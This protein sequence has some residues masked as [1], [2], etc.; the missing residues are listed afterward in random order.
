MGE[1]VDAIILTVVKT[2]A[3]EGFRGAYYSV[4]G[5]AVRSVLGGRR[6][7]TQGDIE[8]LS[9]AI[10]QAVAARESSPRISEERLR[11]II[12]EEIQRAL[13]T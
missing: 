8:A 10:A 5:D 12:R 1:I 4:V 6:T 9:R 3:R 2:L 11:E 7:V 13:R